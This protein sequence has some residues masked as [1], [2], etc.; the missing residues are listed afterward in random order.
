ME[1]NGDNAMEKITKAELINKLL[2]IDCSRPVE[3]LTATVPSMVK[4]GNIFYGRVVKLACYNV[5]IGIHYENSVNRAL[6]REGKPQTFKAKPRKWGVRIPNTPL[7]EH[8]GKYYL[9]CQLNKPPSNPTYILDNTVTLMPED[10]GD[11]LRDPKPPL[12]QKDLQKKVY[13]KDFSI[14]SIVEIHMNK[15]KYVIV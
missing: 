12:T 6:G 3:I 9:E 10:L 7:V 13:L 2:K 11:Y 1:L 5:F 4:T 14:D 8:K 15:E